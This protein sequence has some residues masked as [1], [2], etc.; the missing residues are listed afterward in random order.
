MISRGI[1]KGDRISV[2]LKNPLISTMVMFGI[3]KCG[4]VFSPINFN[5]RGKLLSYQLKDSQPK[6]LITER[7]MVPILNEIAS[8]IEGIVTFVHN[9]M[10]GEHD[11]IVELTDISLHANYNEISFERLL[12]GDTSNL[13][14]E[15][16]YWD[17]ANIIYTSGTTGPAKGVVQSHRWI[18]GYTVGSRQMMSYD[19]VIY[20]DLP[21]YH[22]GGAFFNVAK[23]HMKA[24]RL[25]FG[26]NS[27]PINFG[28][29]LKKQVNDGYAARCY[30]SMANERGAERKRSKQYVK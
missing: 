16:N 4:A 10:E 29:G 12:R 17:T 1:H 27:V 28:A 24:V 11:F 18:N 9:P 21:L 7:M 15:L 26:I 5:Y 25:L 13:D 20:N 22:V 23:V 8:E 2:F 3:W 30:D 14:V 19:D 6:M